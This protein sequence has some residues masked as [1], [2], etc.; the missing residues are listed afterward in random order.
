MDKRFR[1]SFVF[2]ASAL[3]FACSK[4]PTAGEK[5][6]TPVTGEQKSD[7]KFEPVHDNPPAPKTTKKRVRTSKTPAKYNPASGPVPFSDL[8]PQNPSD[9]QGRMIYVASDDTCYVQLP[10]KKPPEHM[11][12]GMPWYAQGPVDCPAE[13]DDPAWDECQYGT[14]EAVEG[15]AECYCIQPGGNPPPP[16]SKVACPKHGK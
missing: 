9:A 7:G 3:A 8:A 11:L 15:K 1:P 12:P 16:P 10:L 14:L 4:E 6:I 5:P 13:L 2:T